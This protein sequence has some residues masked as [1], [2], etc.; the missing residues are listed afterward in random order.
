MRGKGGGAGRYFRRLVVAHPFCRR[1]RCIA[2]G[3]HPPCTH[4][5]TRL[6]PPPLHPLA[7]PPLSP[8]SAHALQE[9]S[10]SRRHS[11]LGRR[12]PWRRA[13]GVNGDS[14]AASQIGEP[15]GP[16]K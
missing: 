8:P 9:P 1:S 7:S 2:G 13:Q 16:Q 3:Q 4:T 14:H 5:H 11:H 12:R 15:H 6:T 10:H